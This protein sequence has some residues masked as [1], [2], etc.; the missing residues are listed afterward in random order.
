M[1]ERKS[2]LTGVAVLVV[3]ALIGG[4]FWWQNNEK[5]CDRWR[6]DASALADDLIEAGP[7]FVGRD[8]D[9]PAFRPYLDRVRAL[10]ERRPDGC[11]APESPFRQVFEAEVEG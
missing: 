11:P 4:F 5:N 1:A 3:I 9:D 8:A 7:N 10:T 2:L 6:E